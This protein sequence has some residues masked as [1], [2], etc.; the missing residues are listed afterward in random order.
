[1][2]RPGEDERRIHTSAISGDCFHVLDGGEINAAALP[3]LNGH[4]LD[5]K[6][7]DGKRRR[8]LDFRQRDGRVD[9]LNARQS[10]QF[11]EEEALIGIDVG[12]DDPQHEIDRTHEDVTFEHLVKLAYRGREFVEVGTA[13]RVELHLRENLSLEAKLVGRVANALFWL[14]KK[15][16]LLTS[17]VR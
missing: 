16:I 17:M 9:F 13:V 5:R 8:R 7:L 12:G 4:G 11:F 6:T 14:R 15:S 3:D 10:G 1:M 2:A